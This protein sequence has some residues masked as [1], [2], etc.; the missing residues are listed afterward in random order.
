VRSKLAFGLRDLDEMLRGGVRPGSTTM[1]FGSS[2]SGKTL[3]GMQF[4]SEGVRQNERVVYFGFYERPESILAK[5]QRVGIGGLNEGVERGLAQII[6]HRPVEGVIDELGESLIRAVSDCRA[7]RLFVDG[8]EGFERAADFPER[9]S[10]V[11]SAIAEELERLGV[12]TIY[13]TETRELFARSIEVPITGLSAATQNIIV[14]RHIEHRASMR[15]VLAILKIRDDDYDARVR[16]IQIT[17]D[18]I[19]LLD[20]FDF[21]SSVASGGGMP[22][23]MHTKVQEKSACQPNVRS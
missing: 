2:G 21:E 8:M 19:R 10:H 7:Q 15:R 18:G 22:S 13:S 1:L 12:T 4:L 23:D 5:C 17:D 11:Y 9:M 20:A 14:M 3:L 16:E 6:W